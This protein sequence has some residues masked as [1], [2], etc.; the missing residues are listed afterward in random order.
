MIRKPPVRNAGRGGRARPGPALRSAPPRGRPTGPTPVG[1]ARRL[2]DWSCWFAMGSV[3]ELPC[4][5]SAL[6]ERG[7]S[8]SSVEWAGASG[9]SAGNSRQLARRVGRTGCRRCWCRSGRWSGC[10]SVPANQLRARSNNSDGDGTSKKRLIVVSWVVVRTGRRRPCCLPWHRRQR[11]TVW[12]SCVVPVAAAP[13]AARFAGVSVPGSAPAAPVAGTGGVALPRGVPT[14]GAAGDRRISDAVAGWNV[15]AGAMTCRS[16][17]GDPVTCGWTGVMPGWTS[18]PEGTGPDPGLVGGPA[19]AFVA[20]PAGVDHR[21]IAGSRRTIAVGRSEGGFGA[22][23]VAVLPVCS[24]RLATGVS[25]DRR[26]NGA[27]GTGRP[28]TLFRTAATAGADNDCPIDRALTAA[29]YRRCRDSTRS[30]V[31]TPKRGRPALVGVTIPPVRGCRRAPLRRGG[32]YYGGLRVDGRSGGARW[33]G[34]PVPT[35]SGRSSARRTWRSALAVTP[36]GDRVGVT[37]PGRL[38]AS[39]AVLAPAAVVRISRS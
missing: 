3:I 5:S 10:P 28:P 33:C 35:W 8:T 24:D 6:N 1:S 13:N 2:P 23:R 18:D 25:R 38:L 36:T 26:T 27:P 9:V 4:R 16:C 17:R 31:S 29:D 32:R 22:R 11:R 20:G 34:G 39:P 19:G 30:A 37:R 15:N 21:S 12:T 14:G 7:R